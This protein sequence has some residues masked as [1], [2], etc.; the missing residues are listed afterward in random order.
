MLL[1]SG[2]AIFALL[3]L[4]GQMHEIYLAYLESPEDFKK[5]EIAGVTLPLPLHYVERAAQ[6][7]FAAAALALLS[8][9]LVLANHWLGKS[10][11]I[12]YSDRD[13]SDRRFKDWRHAAGLIIA[14]LPW[15]GVCVGMDLA[16]R[17]AKVHLEELQLLTTPLGA[18][19]GEQS[20]TWERVLK[21]A[22]EP[23]RVALE[24]ARPGAFWATLLIAS[25]GGAMMLF[26]HLSRKNH[27][28]RYLALAPMVLLFVAALF[29]PYLHDDSS[30]LSPV[31]VFRAIGPL[32]M[33]L[34]DVMLVFTCVVAL[35][36]LSREIPPAVVALLVALVFLNF[37][38]RAELAAVPHL[39]TAAFL[40]VAILALL[41][42][43][44]HLAIFSAIV[45]WLSW[46]PMG[47]RAV[48][49]E[50]VEHVRQ[51]YDKWL[52]LRAADKAAYQQA[53]RDY[54]V[55]IIAAEGGGIYAAAAISAFLS[56][57]QERCPSFA[58][59][60]FAIS[61]V[62]GGAVGA[63]V[64]QS[65]LGNR[66][67]ELGGCGPA[68][69]GSSNGLA[70]KTRSAIQDDHLS[71]LLGFTLADLLGVYRDRSRGLERSLVQSTRKLGLPFQKHW[72]PDKAAPAL[73]LNATWVE[74][75]HRVAFAPFGLE[76]LGGRTLHSFRDN[77]FG[78]DRRI[79]KQHQTDDRQRNGITPQIDQKLAKI[80]LA[81]AA[82]VSARFPAVLPAFTINRDGKRW[83]FVDG[84][85]R[86]SSGALT[87][88]DIFNTIERLS[89]KDVKP[90][91]ILLTGARPG[92]DPSKLHG[93]SARDVLAPVIA[94]LS[95]RARL[96]EDAV[97]RTIVT[98][99]PEKSDHRQERKSP[100]F[101]RKARLVELDDR[102]FTFALGWRI[103]RSTHEIVSLQMG[104]PEVCT[105]SRQSARDPAEE[106][107]ERAQSQR[108]SISEETLVANSCVMHAVV[109][110]L[111]LRKK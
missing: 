36:L 108:S 1:V 54:P 16:R 83:N 88:L 71:P 38:F 55:F 22:A 52:S 89:P 43:E 48:P 69:Q 42:A 111:S 18:Q 64:F 101:D 45:A 57:L 34:F 13:A 75:G 106:M 53:G 80:T 93:T 74:N 62:S 72:Q 10:A 7:A 87:A 3:A 15:L 67:I 26:L 9:V 37:F 68:D 25:C 8:G 11:D 92:F 79:D 4:V 19:P 51:S 78:Y 73:V 24:G 98:V 105:A 23:A 44:W 97:A 85:Y 29:P 91:L 103:S 102:R 81:E 110:L 84:G 109:D 33:I 95:V 2:L 61:G 99:D 6:F 90:R 107:D 17:L 14:A 56:Q 30:M 46:S 20:G 41:S 32:A 58:Q 86:D 31:T 59:H 40:G 49:F 12:F 82:V 76:G 21:Q 47:D 65:L 60:V 96:A 35:T 94:L 5:V 27:K 70:K 66:D 28:M 39:M 50:P 104:R 77:T 63:A 100:V